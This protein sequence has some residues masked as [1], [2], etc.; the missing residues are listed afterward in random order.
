M[1]IALKGKTLPRVYTQP[2]PGRRI[3]DGPNAGC[4]CGCA[5]SPDTSYGFAVIGFAERIK[6]K[7][8]LWQQWLLIH[9]LELN[10]ACTSYRFRTVLV[11]VARQNGKTLVKMVLTLWRMF[12][13]N[14][15][16][17]VGTAQDL[18]QAREVMG[19]GLVPMILSVPE[20]SGRFNPDH[21]IPGERV[22]IWHKT[23]ADEFIRLDCWHRGTKAIVRGDEPRYLIK[24]LNRKAGRG[25]AGVR[26]VNIDELREQRDFAGWAAISKPVMAVEDAQIWCMSN[27]GDRQSLL[28]NH[29]RSIGLAGSDD[30][31]FHAEWSAVE[32]CELDDREQWAQA[33]PSLGHPGGISED[34]IRSAL[35]SD[36]PAVFRT[37]V[38]CQNVDSLNAAIDSQ[39][40]ADCADPSGSLDGHERLA[41]CVGAAPE[42]AHVTAVVAGE[43]EDGRVR[44]EVVGEWDST[45]EARRGLPELHGLLKPK[46]FGWFPKGPGAALSATVRK[47]GAKPIAGAAVSEACMT[48]NDRVEG[49]RLLHPADGLLDAHVGRTSRVGTK[50]DWMFDPGSPELCD[51]AWAAAGAVHLAVNLPVRRARGRRM[52]TPDSVTHP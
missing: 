46:A 10:R 48:L 40:W 33:N 8:F 47:L 41:L 27:A 29:L 28:L 17:I 13:Q 44:V 9:A 26:E 5:L 22:G 31:M 20:L 15:R 18:S 3:G 24:A 35:H 39:G 52:L 25:L 16:L 30:Q 34:A 19:E 12:D 23:L 42:G 21:E 45:A 7:L 4:P 43:L 51:G 6:V 32:G 37:E 36:P 11:L 1:D 50:S 49:R 2:L 14:A 38:L